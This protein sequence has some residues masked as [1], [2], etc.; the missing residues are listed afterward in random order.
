MNID[1]VDEAIS[2]YKKFINEGIIQRTVDSNNDTVLS[3]ITNKPIKKSILRCCI[4]SCNKKLS[5]SSNFTCKCDKTKS[6]CSAHR[7]PEDH[8]C[9]SII[10][11]IKLDKVAPDSMRGGRI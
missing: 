4:E 3:E 10:E 8:S 11:K 5:L 1:N 9:T 7:M 6:Y 2:N